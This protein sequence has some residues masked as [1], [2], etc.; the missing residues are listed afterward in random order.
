VNKMHFQ[1]KKCDAMS[2]GAS[3]NAN[4]KIGLHYRQTEIRNLKSVRVVFVAKLF[5]V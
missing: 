4:A 5:G 1:C 2:L 3:A